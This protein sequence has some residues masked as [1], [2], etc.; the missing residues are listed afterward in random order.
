MYAHHQAGHKKKMSTAAFRIE[1]SMLCI[2]IIY[3]TCTDLE[4][5]GTKMVKVALYVFKGIKRLGKENTIELIL[6]MNTIILY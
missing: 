1:T 2:C 6:G 3:N 4:S 5:L